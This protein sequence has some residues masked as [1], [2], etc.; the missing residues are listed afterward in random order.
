MQCTGVGARRVRQVYDLANA[1]VLVVS[2]DGLRDLEAQFT[3]SAQAGHVDPRVFATLSERTL[4]VADENGGLE[5][6]EVTAVRLRNSAY[7]AI[8]KDP[9]VLE[10]SKNIQA[11]LQGDRVGSI[12][13]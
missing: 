9:R 5:D 10:V 2:M 7:A 11:S 4:E 1:R 6:G 12:S 8:A 3:S 13:S